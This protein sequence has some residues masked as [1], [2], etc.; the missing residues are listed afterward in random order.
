MVHPLAGKPAP[1]DSQLVDMPAIL[2]MAS[3]E[4][5]EEPMQQGMIDGFA[6]AH[7]ALG[8]A[9][10]TTGIMHLHTVPGLI[11]RRLAPSR[12]LIPLLCPSNAALT[13]MITSR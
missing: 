13:S 12:G 7:I 4:L 5:R 3:L 2:I 9:G 8:D 10:F 11:P 1:A 6:T